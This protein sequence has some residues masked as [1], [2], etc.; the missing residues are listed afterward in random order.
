MISL[1]YRNNNFRFIAVDETTLNV[2][3]KLAHEGFSMNKNRT[4]CHY[5]VTLEAQ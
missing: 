5:Y 2:D 3:I 4:Y 1:I